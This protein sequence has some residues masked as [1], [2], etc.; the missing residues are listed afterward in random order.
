MKVRGIRNLGYLGMVTGGLATGMSA[1]TDNKQDTALM[2][3]VIKEVRT[4]DSLRFERKI[5]SLKK[6]FF[7]RMDT[8]LEDQKTSI[9]DSVAKST[10]AQP[11]VTHYSLS[12][13]QPLNLNIDTVSKKSFEA[14]LAAGRLMQEAQ[15]SDD[16]LKKTVSVPDTVK[17]KVENAIAVAKEVVSDTVKAVVDSTKAV[18]S[19]SAG[20]I[21]DGNLKKF[22]IEAIADTAARL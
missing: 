21:L 3:Q 19:E 22:T 8:L 12:W 6:Y 16:S 10:P 18:K 14:G 11:R 4:S 7:G 13:K 5:D 15:K 1:C 17:A 2:E 9:L 20:V